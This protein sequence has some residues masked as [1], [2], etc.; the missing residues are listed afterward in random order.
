ML[1]KISNFS[2][3]IT[4]VIYILLLFSLTLFIGLVSHDSWGPWLSFAHYLLKSRPCLWLAWEPG[5]VKEGPSTGQP[6]GQ[7][8]MPRY[9]KNSG[10]STI[11]SPLF[12]SLE[13]GIVTKELHKQR[14]NFNDTKHYEGETHGVQTY[15]EAGSIDYWLTDKRTPEGD[16]T[17]GDGIAWIMHFAT[18]TEGIWPG[19]LKQVPGRLWRKSLGS[20]KGVQ[21]LKLYDTV[22]TPHT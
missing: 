18:R 7:E 8:Q 11:S 6:P 3:I 20:L 16:K 15:V 13:K 22:S 12:I 21:T 4:G 19:T 5:I 1:L 17:G 14:Q 10:E 2:K 9:E